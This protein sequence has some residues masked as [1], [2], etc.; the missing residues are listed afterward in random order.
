[1][2]IAEWKDSDDVKATFANASIIVD[3]RIVFNIKGNDYRLVCH[4]EYEIGNVMIK[5]FGTHKE[6]DKIN[7]ETIRR[8][9]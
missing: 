6:Y 2:K 7:A 1:V 9:E 4:V 5:W 8:P 3:N